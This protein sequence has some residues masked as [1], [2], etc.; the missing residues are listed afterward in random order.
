MPRI[1]EPVPDFALLRSDGTL[2]RLADFTLSLF[3]GQPQQTRRATS[4]SRTRSRTRSS[5]M[6]RRGRG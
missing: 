6:R 4:R 2:V 1:D 5:R 3:F